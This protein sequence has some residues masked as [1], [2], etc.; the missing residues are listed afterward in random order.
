VDLFTIKKQ[1]DGFKYPSENIHGPSSVERCGKVID[2]VGDKNLM[3]LGVQG[4]RSRFF[5]GID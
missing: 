5:F 2:V 3:N 1:E 4:S